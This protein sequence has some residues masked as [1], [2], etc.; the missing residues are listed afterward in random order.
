MFDDTL[1]FN[2]KELFSGPLYIILDGG[3]VERVTVISVR[4][5]PLS[6]I[7]ILSGKAIL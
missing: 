2:N 1:D 4:W 7:Q 3:S 6:V 5:L